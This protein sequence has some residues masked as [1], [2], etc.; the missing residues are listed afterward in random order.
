[1]QTRQ[2]YALSIGISQYTHINKLERATDDALDMAEVLRGAASPAQVKLLVDADAKKPAILRELKWLAKSAGPRDTAIVY[3]SGHG[4]RQSTEAGAQA[5][6]CPVETSATALKKTCIA[7]AELSTALRAI[8]SERLVVLL[9]TCYS[10]GIGEPR[11][12]STGLNASLSSRDVS[13]LIEGCGRVIMAASRPDERAWNLEEMRNGLFTHYLLQGL[14]GKAVRADGTIWM[15]ETFSYVSRGVRQ[16]GCQ[17]PYQKAIGEDFVLMVQHR[18][19][20]GPARTLSLEP[21]ESNQRFLRLAMRGTYNR[22][23]LALL[24]R[25]LG[26]SLEDLPGATLETQLMDLI[27]HCNR[28]GLYDQLIERVRLDRPQITLRC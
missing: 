10:G 16:H 14:Q 6:F 20:S 8:K 4:G 24:C 17:H 26:L 7:S 15:S 5:Y 25:D 28:H 22:A 21:S 23:E 2:I 3:Y 19:T 11:H 1:M 27:D 13:S 9:D 12:R 18:T